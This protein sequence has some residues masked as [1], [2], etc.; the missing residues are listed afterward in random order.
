[1]GSGSLGTE[2]AQLAHLLAEVGLSPRDTLSLHLER[3]EGLV[4]GLGN[5]ST[6]HVMARADL[7]ALE[8]IIHLGE[9]YQHSAQ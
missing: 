3:V 4:R 6:R 8:L 5:R 7:L 9:C 1:M 2:I